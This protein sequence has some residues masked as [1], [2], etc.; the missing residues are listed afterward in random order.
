MSKKNQN[1]CCGG[2]ECSPQDSAGYTRRDF[3]STGAKASLFTTILGGL[4]MPAMAGPFEASNPYHRLIP[5]DKKLHP[6]WVKSLSERGKKEVYNSKASKQHIGMPIGGIFTGTLYL[7]GAHYGRAMVSYGVYQS[8]CGY[9]YHGPKGEIS[10]KIE[11][12]EAKGH[13]PSGDLRGSKADLW[14]G[15][16]RVPFIVRWPNKIKAKST[17]DELICLSDM[18]AT[19]ADLFSVSI[20]DTNAEDS[21]SF[22]P[23][24]Y[25]ETVEKPREA[26]VHHSIHGRFSIRQGDEKLLLAPGSGGWTSPLDVEA[27]KQG[28]PEMQLYDLANDRGENKNLVNEHPEKVKSLI[29]LLEE[30]V[31]NVRSMPGINQ[32]NDVPVDIWKTALNSPR[33][34]NTSTEE[35]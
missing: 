21:I 35:D 23:L 30:M 7:G 14:D 29:K 15:G 12:L 6:D 27:P 34:R 16:H 9:Q 2:G 8:I 33:E 25:G 17:T 5:K 4:P 28:L 1:T 20:S 3:L 32:K 19:F 22:L 10:A 24:I 26:I 18:T 31:A 13:F 11:E